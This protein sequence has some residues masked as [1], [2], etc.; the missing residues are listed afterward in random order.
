MSLLLFPSAWGTVNITAVSG[1][2][3]T[4]VGESVTTIYG[5]MAGESCSST[6]D[7]ET[8]SNCGDTSKACNPHRV[9]NNL[10]LKISFS[11]DSIDSGTPRMWDADGN[12]VTLVSESGTTPKNSTATIGVRWSS[13]CN[14]LDTTSSGSCEGLTLY[15]SIYVGMLGSNGSTDKKEVKFNIYGSTA[16]SA[17]CAGGEGDGVCDIEMVK[18]DEK[19][20]FLSAS[21]IGNFPAA[22]NMFYTALRVIYSENQSGPFLIE[23]E[24]KSD[25]TI[26]QESGDQKVVFDKNT[27]DGLTNG[28]TYYFVYGLVDTAGNIGLFSSYAGSI[29]PE[30]V[31]GLLSNDVNCFVATAAYGSALAPEVETLRKFRDRFLLPHSLGKKVVAYY[32]QKSPTLAELIR[33]NPSLKILTQILLWPFVA[34]AF[35]FLHWGGSLGLVLITLPILGTALIWFF[36][37]RKPRSVL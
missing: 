34:L 33:R 13:V 25:V 4:V 2:S 31:Y 32:Y 9:Y 37:N 1:A 6:D 20:Y 11:S 7:S 5:G 17:D 10:E 14:E 27:V 16:N 29:T 35:L 26:S 3:N 23:G 15:G 36:L 19:A 21:Y 22:N 24:N 30:S 18:G 12:T 8:C 28:V